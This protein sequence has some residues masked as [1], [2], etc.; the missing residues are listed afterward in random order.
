MARS[1]LS[2]RYLFVAFVACWSSFAQGATTALTLRWDAPPDCPTAAEI[3]A[4]LSRLVAPREA[5]S[6]QLVA[7]ATTEL[8]QDGRYHLTL[9]TSQAGEQGERSF[10]G[11]SCRIVSDAAIVTIALC[12]D[13]RVELANIHV[14]NVPELQSR[15]NALVPS[16]TV[17]APQQTQ[18]AR[19]D[20]ARVTLRKASFAWSVKPQPPMQLLAQTLVG[21]QWGMLPESTGEVG[22]SVGVRRS[23]V[24]GYLQLAMSPSSAT[25]ASSIK[26]DAGGTFSLFSTQLSGCVALVDRPLQVSPCV[27]VAWNYVRARGTEVEPSRDGHLYWPSPLAGLWLSYRLSELVAVVL[28]AEGFVPLRQPEAYLFENESIF[29]PN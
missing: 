18:S 12:L 26:S 3:E 15:T 17:I 13:P 19:R 29:K 22:V 24:S 2:N 8:D 14:S 10:T 20:A 1:P 21:W 28:G 9:H 5:V 23:R 25:A 6:S 16:T 7:E 27:G 4:T 11:Q